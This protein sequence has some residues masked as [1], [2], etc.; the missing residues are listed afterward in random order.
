MRRDAGPPSA[1]A[2]SGLQEKQD[3]TNAGARPSGSAVN[4]AGSGSRTMRG[5]VVSAL[6]YNAEVRAILS[7]A[8]QAGVNISIA[9]SGYM[10]TLESSAGIG[11]GQ[12]QDYQISL[13]Q[14]L[15]DFGQTSAKV[16]RAEAGRDVVTAELKEA[17]EKAAL[18]AAQ[19]YIAVQRANAL[20]AIAKENITIIKHFEGLAKVRAEGG[21]ADISEQE[22][23]GVHLGDAESTLREEEGLLRA[24]ES[25]F[26]AKIGMVPG[27][28]AAAP[29]LRLKISDIGQV[30]VAA[31]EAPAVDVAK[32]REQEAV[33]AVSAEKASLYPVVSA[34]AYHRGGD[35]GSNSGSGVGLRIKGPSLNGLANFQRVEAM[36]YAAQSARWGAE[37]AKRN[38]SA[39]VKEF[40][41]REPTLSSQITIL[42]AQ[43]VRARKLRDLYEDQFKL[44]ERKLIDLI[45]VQSDIVRNQRSGVNA[46]HDI[47]ALQYSAVGALG[48]LQE[49]L[50]IS[51][52]ETQR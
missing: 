40:I 51:S 39:Q 15:Y 4:A 28:L 49:D 41:D 46:R 32:A 27:K 50:G 44:G 12:G 16:S 5:A 42:A 3:A 9:K 22:L 47:L 18:E 34:E 48:K 38:A 19:S 24:A 36:T 25:A 7:N 14:P 6:G 45:T 30:D 17:R 35:S 10:P 21:V 8:A 2:S 13:T 11:T 1:S 20:V 31:G 52:G 23:A 33:H 37:A 43:L 26:Y 29:D